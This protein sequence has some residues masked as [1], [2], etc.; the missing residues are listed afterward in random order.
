VSKGPPSKG[1][2][3]TAKVPRRRKN[4]PIRGPNPGSTTLPE[5]IPTAT[6]KTTTSPRA[7]ALPRAPGAWVGGEGAGEAAPTAAAYRLITLKRRS[8]FL[9]LRKGARAST[10]AFVLEAK[11]R[12]T[13]ISV[14]TVDGPRFGFTIARQVGNAVERNRIRRRLKA[15]IVGAA[16]VHARRDFDYVVI[17]RRAALTRPFGA[18]VADLINALERIH[19]PARRGRTET[20]NTPAG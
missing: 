14:A 10:S 20:D 4:G 12:S 15:A 5:T 19:R 3:A 7:V 11:A 6:P 9:R 2:K 13:G 18:L 16:A 1:P 17:A 8:E